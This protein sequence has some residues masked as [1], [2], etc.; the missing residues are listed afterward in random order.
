MKSPKFPYL[1]V[2]LA[3][4]LSIGL[5]GSSLLA[6]G[7]SAQEIITVATLEYPPWTGKNLKFNGFVNH[8]ISEAFKRSGYSVRFTYLP[9][10][11]AVTETKNGKYAALSYVYYSEA[12]EK[13][14]HLS[15]PISEEKIVF[16]HLKSNPIRD[17]KTLDDLKNYRFGATRGYTYTQ[18]FWEAAESK[19]IKVDITDSD[20]QNFKKLFAGRID[21]FPSGLV[22]GYSF[23]RKE[24]QAGKLQL[25]SYH[26]KPL[27]ATT[28]HL[29]FTKSRKNSENLRQIFNRGLAELKKEG[30]Y[31]EFM[32]NLLAGKY[33]Q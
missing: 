10:E 18:E 4:M 21:I 14:F 25:L 7:A 13:E 2:W 23:L 11:R 28:G 20:K 8:V 29:A 3:A 31:D 1:I 33:S 6:S 17:W 19:R 15:G 22:N 32:A 12:R 9:W 24:F 26:P 5:V 27:S 30:L 16:F